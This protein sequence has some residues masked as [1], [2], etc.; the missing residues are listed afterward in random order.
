MNECKVSLPSLQPDV[1][2][3]IVATLLKQLGDEDDS[4][5]NEIVD[6]LFCVESRNIG[7]ANFAKMVIDATK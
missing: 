5:I 3:A 7:M 4:A 6:Y 1:N 2:A